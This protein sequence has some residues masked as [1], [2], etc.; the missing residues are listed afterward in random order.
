MQQLLLALTADRDRSSRTKRRLPARDDVREHVA[1]RL[2]KWTAT[3]PERTR[4]A[5]VD[6]AGHLGGQP[7]RDVGRGANSLPQKKRVRCL[8]ERRVAPGEVLAG[9]QQR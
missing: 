2:R 8:A 1:H 5:V 3:Q 7:E 9:T 4:G 6:G